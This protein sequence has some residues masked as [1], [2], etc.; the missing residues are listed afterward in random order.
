MAKKLL[1]DAATSK[2]AQRQEGRGEAPILVA[3][4][5][6]PRQPKSFRLGPLHLE[7]LRRLT[8]RLSEEAGR[9]LSET[10]LIKGLLLLGEKTDAKKLLAS[11][12]DAVFESK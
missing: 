3:R 8:D 6:T 12:K 2:L 9:P 1:A 7:R 10:E 4:R 5:K 11:V